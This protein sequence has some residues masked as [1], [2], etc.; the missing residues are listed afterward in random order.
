MYIN[1][2]IDMLSQSKICSGITTMVF[3]L[4]I[5]EM[6]KSVSFWDSS[7]IEAEMLKILKKYGWKWPRYTEKTDPVIFLIYIQKFV[8]I[9][10]GRKN[11]VKD[12]E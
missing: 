10:P 6:P 12:L 1:L 7:I 4:S 8:K 11:L 5:F 3:D 9:F 2:Y